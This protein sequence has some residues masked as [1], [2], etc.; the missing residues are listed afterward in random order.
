MS[1]KHSAKAEYICSTSKL[2]GDNVMIA[3]KICSRFK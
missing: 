1:A 3:S 2:R